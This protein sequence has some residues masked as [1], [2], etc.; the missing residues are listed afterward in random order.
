MLPRI[1]KQPSTSQR[2]FAHR[3]TVTQAMSPPLECLAS[4]S[5]F[6]PTP[7]SIPPRDVL[8]RIPSPVNSLPVNLTPLNPIQFLL[9]AALICPDKLAIAHPDVKHPVYYSYGVW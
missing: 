9:R 6:R 2:R 1:A 8:P 5:G 7:S 3:E 4:E